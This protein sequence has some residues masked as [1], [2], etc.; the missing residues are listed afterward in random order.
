MA[1]A[2]WRDAFLFL[3]VW[4][5]ASCASVFNLNDFDPPEQTTVAALGGGKTT[6]KDP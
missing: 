1:F 3:E 2:Y 5:V 6:G 4:L